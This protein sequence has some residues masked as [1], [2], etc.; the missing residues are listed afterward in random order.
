MDVSVV[1]NGHLAGFGST[2]NSHDG[3]FVDEHTYKVVDKYNIS[4]LDIP[5]NFKVELFGDVIIK[6]YTPADE[7][8]VSAKLYRQGYETIKDEDRARVWYVCADIDK[9]SVKVETVTREI[10]TKLSW[11]DAINKLI[12]Q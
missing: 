3:Y 5:D 1:I 7:P 12:L 8:R 6:G 9:S 10:N 2:H 11:L 4:V